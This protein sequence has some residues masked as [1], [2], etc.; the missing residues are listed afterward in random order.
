MKRVST[1]ALVFT[2]SLLLCAAAAVGARGQVGVRP[3]T[4]K[5]SNG[6]GDAEAAKAS[7]AQTLYEEAAQYAQRKFDE[8]RQQQVPYD[9]LLEQKTLQEQKD[10]A[11]QNAARL[12]ARAP[13]R[14][15]DLYYSGLLYSLAGK[16]EG[17]LDSL[18]RFLADTDPAP[19]DLKQRARSVTA[20]QAAQL[21]LTEEAEHVLA[22]Y[23]KAEPRNVA[24]LHRMSLLLASAYVKKKDFVRAAAPAGDAYAAALEYARTSRDPV[25]R[26]T[27]IFGAG[28]FYA[29]VL[30]KAGRRAEGISV[31]QEMRAFGFA[32]PSAR[33]YGQATELVLRQGEPFGL[34]PEVLG[35]TP[36]ASPEINVAE[37]IGRG[38]VKLS[39][40]RG[41]V[42][43][44]DF[45][46]TWC[47]YC[48][49]TMPRLNAMH[50]K[51]KD[52]GLVIIGLNEFEGHIEGQPATRAQELEYFRQFKRRMN[53]TYDFAVAADASNAAP[54]GVAGLP[55]A[56]LVDR[57]GRVR[58]LTIGASD[59]EAELLKKMVLTLLDEP[60]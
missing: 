2:L 11:L 27:T 40:L 3:E 54:Y 16:G 4:E 36:P 57:R 8:F 39:E 56:V 58:F 44:L 20:Q 25:Q 43:L 19:P 41:K 45:W 30:I 17:A 32:F 38:P 29:N 50:Q 9:R 49:K 31:A 55:T 34:P 33:L 1:F 35:L 48:V 12:A 28:S 5:E 59:E 47:T 6:K 46:A 21:G 23:A 7:E 26:D 52:R 15:T 13:L 14:G 24:D 10:L 37:L 18:R 53:V 51:Y 22:D 42:V 60:Q